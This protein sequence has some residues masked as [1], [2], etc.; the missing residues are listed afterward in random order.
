MFWVGAGDE[1]KA[2]GKSQQ[3]L[4]QVT[5]QR[6]TYTIFEWSEVGLKDNLYKKIFI[7]AQPDDIII[8]LLPCLFI[9]IV[10][11]MRTHNKRWL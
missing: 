7:Q 4:V 2:V 8:G 5:T 10:Q 1:G 3:L 11:N 9:H 6:A